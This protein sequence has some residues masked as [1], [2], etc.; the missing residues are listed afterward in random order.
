LQTP[1]KNVIG[2]IARQ[3]PGNI[4]WSLYFY[5]NDTD[6]QEYLYFKIK[7]AV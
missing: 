1:D 4:D 3:N 6:Y 5:I 2:L 7:K